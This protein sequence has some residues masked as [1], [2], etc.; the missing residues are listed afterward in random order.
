MEPQDYHISGITNDDVHK[1]FR[2]YEEHFP[3]PKSVSPDI[4]QDAQTQLGTIDKLAQTVIPRLVDKL[5]DA[6]W[7]IERLTALCEW[8]H[9][10]ILDLYK[11][12]NETYIP[13]INQLDEQVKV[14]VS[15]P[16]R[17]R[18]KKEIAP[19]KPEVDMSE[20]ADYDPD[21][22]TWVPMTIDGHK[23]TGALL[24]VVQHL[25]GAVDQ[26]YSDEL[27]DFCS[28]LEPHIR[29]AIAERFPN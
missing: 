27:I 8:Q 15:K 18:K 20:I 24:D 1:H 6:N 13:A 23:I 19:A 25:N 7:K 9:S 11:A 2:W 3:Y 21:T 22:D 12:I 17:T 29:T 26:M 10:A 14:L 5:N 4:P 16:K 28:N